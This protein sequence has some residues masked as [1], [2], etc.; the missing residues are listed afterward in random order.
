MTTDGYGYLEPETPWTQKAFR[1]ALLGLA[2]TAALALIGLVVG[3]AGERPLLRTV[4]WAEFL[5][6][7]GISAV[8]ALLLLWRPK[9]PGR[10][11]E[12]EKT[13]DVGFGVMLAGFVAFASALLV[14]WLWQV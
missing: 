1:A 7:T 2:F 4:M 5:G 8:G 14:S 12:R 10:R 9:E 3:L 13:A 11:D 6:G